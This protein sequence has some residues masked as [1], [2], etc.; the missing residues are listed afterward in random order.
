MLLSTA[1]AQICSLARG[2][3]AKPCWKELG[4]LSKM[5]LTPRN[6]VRFLVLGV[7]SAPVGVLWP[8]SPSFMSYYPSGVEDRQIR[9]ILIINPPSTPATYLFGIRP[10]ISGLNIVNLGDLT[11][12]SSIGVTLKMP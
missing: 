12:F 9:Y 5:S 3:F 11:P 8:A 4:Q 1:L 2:L 6:K 10:G 7:W